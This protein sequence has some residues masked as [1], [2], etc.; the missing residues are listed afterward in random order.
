MWFTI[1]IIWITWFPTAK[2]MSRRE[3]PPSWTTTVNCIAT[4]LLWLWSRIEHYYCLI[5]SKPWIPV[6]DSLGM[7]ALYDYIPLAQGQWGWYTLVSPPSSIVFDPCFAVSVYYIGKVVSRSAL[8]YIWG[9]ATSSAPT[10]GAGD[11][12][13]CGQDSRSSIL[14]DG[15]VLRVM[16]NSRSA[17]ARIFVWDRSADATRYTQTAKFDSRHS[18]EQQSQIKSTKITLHLMRLAPFV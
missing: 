12:E 11:L 18:G 16:P 1:P 10:D 7:S 2:A 3:G 4:V 9:H 5:V 17:L 15:K 8:S 13:E 6:S 14:L